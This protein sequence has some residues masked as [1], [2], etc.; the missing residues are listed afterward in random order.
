MMKPNKISLILREVWDN[1]LLALPRLLYL[2]LDH[3]S[4]SSGDS[5]YGDRKK[6]VRSAFV[7]PVFNPVSAPT[8]THP[9]AK[10][11]PKI[12]LK[13]VFLLLIIISYAW[14]S[15]DDYQYQIMRAEHGTR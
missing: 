4:Y 10:F 3:T 12:R 13:H 2:Q 8:G 14:V 15:E 5:R 7:D 11:F 9:R 6:D 1:Y